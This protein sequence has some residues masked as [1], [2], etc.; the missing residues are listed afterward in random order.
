MTEIH[1][2][3]KMFYQGRQLIGCVTSIVCEPLIEQV[4]QPDIGRYLSIQFIHSFIHLHIFI[5]FTPKM[6]LIN[7]EELLKLHS[8]IP[9]R[10]GDI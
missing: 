4:D 2:L 9:T 7:L 10:S 3:F 6:D 1:A 8:K 5:K